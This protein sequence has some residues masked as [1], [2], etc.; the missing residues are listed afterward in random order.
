[1][2]SVPMKWKRKWCRCSSLSSQWLNSIGTGEVR[3]DDI[4]FKDAFCIRLSRFLF[5]PLRARTSPTQTSDDQGTSRI[6]H[7]IGA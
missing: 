3:L 4:V 5:D 2:I 6:D 1:M 7:N